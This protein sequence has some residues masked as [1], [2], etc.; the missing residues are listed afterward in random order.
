M[1]KQDYFSEALEIM[2]RIREKKNIDYG[3]SFGKSIDKFGFIS[4]L[5]RIDDKLSRIHNLL[6]NGKAEV[7]DEALEDSIIDAANYILMTRE[8]ILNRKDN[9][10]EVKLYEDI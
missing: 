5:T 3:N 6:K 9:N 8:E 4:A 10:K 7:T 1:E 2:Q